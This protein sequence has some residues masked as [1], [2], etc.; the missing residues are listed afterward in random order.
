MPPNPFTSPVAVP[1]GL[2]AVA[3]VQAVPFHCMAWFARV[4]PSMEA[5]P[6]LPTAQQLA[7]EVHE[8]AV[9][10]L[11]APRTV[12]PGSGV[13]ITVQVTPF[14]CMTSL[15][16]PAPGM[17]DAPTAKQSLPEMQVTSV[18]VLMAPLPVLPGSGVV[19][20][21][22]CLPF[23]CRASLRVAPVVE[24]T[25]LPTA[26][27]SRC[28]MHQALL[29][30]REL[31]G[32]GTERTPAGALPDGVAEATLAC[33]PDRLVADASRTMPAMAPRPHGRLSLALIVIS[34][35][36][37][38][39]GEHQNSEL[40]P[41]SDKPVLTSGGFS[42]LLLKSPGANRLSA[43]PHPLPSAGR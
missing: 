21:D 27:Q 36:S 20:R 16:V 11:K 31:P 1:P 32:F 4:A 5:D 29:S 10:A 15:R 28:E 12:P 13:A 14:H 38:D 41:S 37:P 35:T 30:W 34:L 43:R 7:A 39:H 33:A 6:S 26:Q 18:R 8:I 3:S 9:S 40:A 2:G 22:Q 24:L 25:K 17:L 23:Q 19:T 42:R